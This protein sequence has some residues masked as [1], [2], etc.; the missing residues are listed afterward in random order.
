MD[1]S[2]TRFLVDASAPANESAR[3]RDRDAMSRLLSDAGFGHATASLAQA[4][5]VA[6]TGTAGRD[7]DDRLEAAAGR[8]EATVLDSLVHFARGHGWRGQ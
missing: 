7:Y 8:A 2:D 1:R 5:A 6:V 4:V 3:Q